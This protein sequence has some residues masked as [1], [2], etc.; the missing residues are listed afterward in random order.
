MT[1]GDCAEAAPAKANAAIETA[2]NTS[3]RMCPPAQLF[4]AERASGTVPEISYAG[5]HQYREG[6]RK[7]IAR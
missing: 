4:F 1:I 2:A 3:L 6:G 7:A 5:T